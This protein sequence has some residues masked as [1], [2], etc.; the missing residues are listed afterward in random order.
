MTI[1]KQIASARLDYKL[2]RL[3]FFFPKAAISLRTDRPNIVIAVKP[4]RDAH[5]SFTSLAFLIPEWNK[6]EDERSSPHIGHTMKV[7]RYL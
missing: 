6:P 5:H 3:K 7:A 2:G 1:P 4:I